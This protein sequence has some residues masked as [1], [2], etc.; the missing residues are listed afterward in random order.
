MPQNLKDKQ[1]LMLQAGIVPALVKL[2]TKGKTRAVVNEAVLASVAML[3]GKHDNVSPIVC[4]YPRPLG[5]CGGGGGGFSFN[6]P[7]C[8]PR[9]HTSHH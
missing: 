5:V 7:C 1:R 3:W 8:V 9:Y 2:L 4:V 6:V